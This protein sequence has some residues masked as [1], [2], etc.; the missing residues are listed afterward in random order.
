MSERPQSAVVGTIVLG[1]LAFFTGIGAL[2]FW[3]KY[4]WTQDSFLGALAAAMNKNLPGE[5]LLGFIICTAITVVL[6]IA[7]VKIWK[8]G[9]QSRRQL[10]P[11]PTPMPPPPHIWYD[12]EQGKWRES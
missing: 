12:Q 6:V 8:S 10:P 2:N 4:R 3:D 9:N 7:A 11:P 5:Y 1:V